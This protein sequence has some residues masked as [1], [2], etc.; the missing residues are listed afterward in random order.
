M[1]NKNSLQ[2]IQNTDFI[3]DLKKPLYES[4]CS[5]HIPKSI[6]AI[7]TEDLSSSTLPRDVFPQDFH[8]AKHVVF[9]FIDGLSFD[10]IQEHADRF[11]F[12]K[13]FRTGGKASALTSQF[14]S[15][16]AAHVTL[17]NTGKSPFES[18]IYEWFQ[19]F[20]ILDE[21]IA[22]I[23]Y[24]HAGDK[25]V[26]TLTKENISP[27]M[28]YPQKTIHE[29]LHE[30][31]IL[32][33]ALQEEKIMMSVYTSSMFR[34][35]CMT[36]YKDVLSGFLQLE[37]QLKKMQSAGPSY[38]YMYL[39]Q[40]DSIGHRKG[41]DS[42]DYDETLVH[43]MTELDA[44]M[45]RLDRLQLQ[46]TLIMITSDH[47][48]TQVDPKKTIYLN[49][50]LPNITKTFKRNA[51]GNLL[52]PA[53]SCRDFFLH[54]EEDALAVGVSE[55]K[56]ALHGVAEVMRTSELLEQGVLG[57][58][59]PS[60]RYLKNVGN[61]VILPYAKEAVWWWE[62]G[63]FEQPFYGVHGGLSREELFVPLFTW[64]Y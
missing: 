30:K 7:L 50:I 55:I 49:Q 41:L 20:H 6:E 33:F 47:G 23:M 22:P 8:G 39:S 51:K 60:E 40:L 58:G 44:F 53:G 17:F 62:K 9:I 16:T 43:L 59:T 5:L 35:S 57:Y 42:V 31:D 56:R 38:H 25:A 11:A 18:G 24:S 28:L 61:V 26:D 37:E 13:R 15:T 27:G 48:M 45:H 4:Y 36:G 54:M 21:M 52:V 34:G 46:E 1:F 63:R 19:Y 64:A 14:P 29:R 10:L 2:A 32:S 3:H 12:L